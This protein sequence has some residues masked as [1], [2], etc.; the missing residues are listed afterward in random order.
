LFPQDF[1]EEERTARAGEMAKLKREILEMKKGARAPKLGGKAEAGTEGGTA[2][3][4]LPY[5]GTSLIRN[6][7]P[8]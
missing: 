7:V 6:S 4:V 8:P 1:A 3:K 2:D 5:R